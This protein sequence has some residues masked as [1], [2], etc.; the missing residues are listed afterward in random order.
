MFAPF[1]WSGLGKAVA[2]PR[3]VLKPPLKEL[4][5]VLQSPRAA[6]PPS[7]RTLGGVMGTAV[8]L[9]NQALLT[10]SIIYRS[11]VGIFPLMLKLR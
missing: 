4:I 8:R 6:L 10:E 11:F 9:V 7:I 1:S 2:L 5:S 3:A